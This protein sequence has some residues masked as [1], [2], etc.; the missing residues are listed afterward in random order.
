MG[1]A[2]DPA[3]IDGLAQAGV[4]R[5]VFWLPQEGPDAVDQGFERFA[6]V[7]GQFQTAG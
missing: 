2:P 4:H 7:M 3:R 5:V 6:A 1:M